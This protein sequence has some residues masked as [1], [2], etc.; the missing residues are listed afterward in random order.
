MHS[1]RSRGSALRVTLGRGARLAAAAGAAALLAAV[2]RT[3]AAQAANY[4]AFQP[5]MVVDREFNFG[6]GDGDRGTSVVFQWREGWS[7]VSQLSLD[8]GILDRDGRDEDVQLLVGGAFARQLTRA[9]QDMPLDMLFTAGAYL[10]VADPV[11]FQLP[12]GLSVGHRFPLEGQL[13]ITPFVHPRVALEYCD[14]CGPDDDSETDLGVMFDIGVDFEMTRQLSL[15]AGV[16]LGDD[17]REAIGI[18]LA[19]R[20]AGLRGR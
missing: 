3:V 5:P 20:P 10:A 13:A 19:W 18:S 15:R 1:A 12:V 4:P 6:V 2:P 8:V 7:P 9:S 11:F 16:V 17:D 14:D